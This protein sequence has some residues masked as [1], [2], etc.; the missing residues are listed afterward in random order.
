MN[1]IG[2]TVLV[3]LFALAVASASIAADVKMKVTWNTADNPK[4]PYA[5]TA[6]L[7]QEKL[8]ELMPDTFE[9]QFFPNAQIGDEK[10]A[11]EGMRF[12]TI[13]AALVT[14]AMIATIEPDFQVLDLPFLFKDEAMAH[15]VL[16]GQVG[17]L[18]LSSLEDKGIVGL[19]FAEGGF[20]H[21]INNARPVA[22][23]DDAQGI[24][25]RVMQ[26]PVFIGLFKSIGS[27]PVPISGAEAYAA[28][29]QGTVDGLELPL[30]VIESNGYDEVT[31]YLSLTRHTYSAIGVLMSKRF[32]DKLSEE[33][34]AAV[35]EA[36]LAAIAEERVATQKNAA[37]TVKILEER[38][39]TVNDIEDVKPFRKLV[40]PVYE[41]FRSEISPE[42]FDGAMSATSE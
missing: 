37:E 14:N 1:L 23:P 20:R 9:L 38:G 34:R 25:F 5:I 36:A 19:G 3:T 7:W 8:N 6:H 29:Q 4:D 26:N 40:Q 39:M 12:G 32:Y 16:D 21:M 30:A 27:N 35:R 11:L 42:V 33:Q 13:D 24:K 31:K 10:L 41:E 2:K 15:R 18:L 22:T 28:T 17:E